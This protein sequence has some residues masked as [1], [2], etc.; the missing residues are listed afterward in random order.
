[1]T[2]SEAHE[3]EAK[4]CARFFSSKP[5]IP[6]SLIYLVFDDKFSGNIHSAWKHLS[7]AQ[8]AVDIANNTSNLMYNGRYHYIIV[9]QPLDDL[10]LKNSEQ[11]AISSFNSVEP[12]NISRPTFLVGDI[13]RLKNSNGFRI[14]EITGIFLAT[15]GHENLVSLK[16][17]ETECG[18]AYGLPV[19]ET[20]MPLDLLSTHL[21]IEKVSSTISHHK[22]N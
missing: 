4:D 1:M 7:D 17:L 21:L 10:S 22:G 11:K 6:N 12:T 14:W 8:A 15:L 2:N 13:I 9:D 5:H 16:P 19:H 18:S 3:Q 20:I